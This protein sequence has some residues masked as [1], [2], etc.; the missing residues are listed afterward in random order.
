MGDDNNTPN[1]AKVAVSDDEVVGL[2]CEVKSLLL[3]QKKGEIE[4]VEKNSKSVNKDPYC[5]Y[6]LVSKQSFDENHKLTGTTLEIHS[7]QLLKVLKEVVTYY[8]GETLDFNTKFTIED[9]FMM[10]IHHLDKLREYREISEDMTV[11]MHVALLLDYLAAEAGPK[12]VENNDMIAGGTITFPL[13]W[14]IFK[15]GDIVCQH[16]N[17]HTRLFRV[18]RHGYGEHR[19]GGKYFDL[20]CSF[21][22]FDGEKVGI[23]TDKLRIWDKKEFFGLFPASI[24]EL[25]VFPIKFLESTARSNLLEAMGERAERYLAIKEKCVMQ[26]DGLYL[27]LRRPP[28]DFYNETALYGGTFLPETTTGRIV[29][30]PKTFNEEARAQ[31]EEIAAWESDEEDEKAEDKTNPIPCELF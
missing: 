23:A 9:P 31:K 17:G 29:I 2:Q 18:R 5:K 21:V 6:A 14:M 20:S 11:K 19:A 3:R 1:I 15:P 26:Y 8:P 10:L 25:S 22:S 13:L 24:T 16:D 28:W 12:G 30:D 7:P 27:Y 4:I